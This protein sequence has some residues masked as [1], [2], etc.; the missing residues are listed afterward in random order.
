MLRIL[1]ATDRQKITM[2][3]GFTLVEMTVVIAILAMIAALVVPN[4]I[5]IKRSQDIRV[6]EASLLRAPAEARNEARKAQVPVVLRVDGDVL[7]MERM[8]T[9]GDPE[10]VKRVTL[11]DGVRIESARQGSE[12]MDLA[13]WQWVVYP[14]GS[15]DTGLLEFSEGETRKSLVLAADGNARWVTG[16][17]PEITQEWWPAGELEQRG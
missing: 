4:M 12:T 16:E 8:S 7:V 5:A 14:D 9:E 3:R 13:S 6:M 1:R 11:V 10:E 15:A 2:R 17:V